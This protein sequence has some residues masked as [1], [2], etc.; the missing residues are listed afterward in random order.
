MKEKKN[1]YFKVAAKVM[2]EMNSDFYKFNEAYKG[3]KGKTS[4]LVKI[5]FVS[6]DLL[7]DN[8]IRQMTGIYKLNDPE[9]KGRADSILDIDIP[10][11]LLTNSTLGSVNVMCKNTLQSIHSKG[12]KTPVS[13]DEVKR[14]SFKIYYNRIHSSS[15]TIAER[16]RE[17]GKLLSL[18]TIWYI[19][20]ISGKEKVI[21][22]TKPNSE[23]QSSGSGS[24]GPSND[25]DN[26][27]FPNDP[28][29]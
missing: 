28:D 15:L 22:Y 4:I 27:N 18:G 25:P 23:S 16:L 6:N 12:D 21:V 14:K 26:P 24:E 17:K 20:R 7:E 1:Y 9:L 2:P 29:D 3:L 8:E 10:K 5:S 19:E 13:K 11:Y